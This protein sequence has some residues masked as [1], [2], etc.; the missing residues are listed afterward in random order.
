MKKVFFIIGILISSI[1]YPQTQWKAFIS[2]FPQVDIPFSLDVRIVKKTI[3]ISRND[4]WKYIIKPATII[5]SRKKQDLYNSFP[6]D[7]MIVYDYHQL[8]NLD[9]DKKDTLD[10]YSP[11]IGYRI[12]GLARFTINRDI[13]GI[14]WYLYPSKNINLSFGSRECFWLFIYNNSGEVVDITELNGAE[15]NNTMCLSCSSY[16]IS[17]VYHSEGQTKIRINKVSISPINNE[18]YSP[19]EKTV[20]K[21]SDTT[22]FISNNGLIK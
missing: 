9:M 20:K 4:A 15:G 13:Q 22:Y 16:S 19:E 12:S 11:L 8:D 3:L 17:K 6:I 14:I 7:S 5:N 10:F 18:E 21:Y 2:S 1:A